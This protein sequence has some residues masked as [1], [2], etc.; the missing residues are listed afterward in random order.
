MRLTQKLGGR[1][2]CTWANHRSEHL[3]ADKDNI[4]DY[5]L[6][7]SQQRRG[8]SLWYARVKFVVPVLPS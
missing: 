6:P 1:P 2:T 3:G 7:P 8:V 5:R 4:T